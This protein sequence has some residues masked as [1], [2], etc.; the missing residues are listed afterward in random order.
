[1]EPVD[2]YDLESRDWPFD[3]RFRALTNAFR[4]RSDVAGSALR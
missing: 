2:R 4:V 1:M 3:R